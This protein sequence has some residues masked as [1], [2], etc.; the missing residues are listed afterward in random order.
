MYSKKLIRNLE[1]VDFKWLNNEFFVMDTTLDE[2]LPSIY[3][4]QFVEVLVNDCQDV[5]L[6]RPLSIHDVD[7]SKNIVSFL[8]QIV[9]PGTKKLS[10]LKIGDKINTVFPLGNSYTIPQE[11]SKC[12]LIGGGCG[13]APLLLLARD[14]AKTG[15]KPY[16]IIGGRS[17]DYLLRIEEYKKYGKVFVTT[18]DGSEG[19]KGFVIHSKILWD[20]NYKFDKI[21]T[22]GPEAM[23]KAIAKYAQNNNIECEVS[24]E[25]LM[26]CGIGAC[27]CC[28][29]ETKSGNKCTCTEGP[30]F[31]INELTWLT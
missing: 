29:V 9:G 28:I 30:V 15:I 5:F 2:D 13:V 11:D 6:R 26:A 10:E 14:M 25:N 16:I 18:E 1:I 7:Y 27:L 8:V 24:L 12:L 21:F 19:D 3:P 22:C 23:M 4:G 31:N 17:K 20:E